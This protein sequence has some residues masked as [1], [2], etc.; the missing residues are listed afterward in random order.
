M[1]EFTDKLDRAAAAAVCGILQQGGAALI[2]AGFYGLGRSGGGGAGS[3][4][5][6]AAGLFASSFAG[7]PDPWNPQQ[8]PT[9]PVGPPIPLCYEGASEFRVRG[10]LNGQLNPPVTP[11]IKMIIGIRMEPAGFPGVNDGLEIAVMEW[12]QNGGGTGETSFFVGR[13]DSGNIYGWIQEF[14]GDPTCQVPSPPPGPQFPPYEYT[15]VDGCQLTVN[16][17][18]FAGTPQGVGPV[19][20]ISPSGDQL[21][22]SGPI[23]GCNFQPVLHYG[24]PAGGPP[25]VAPWNPDWDDAPPDDP[26]PWGPV[27]DEIA[28]GIGAAATQ[29]QIDEKFDTPLAEAQYV[30]NSIC[31]IDPQGNPIQKE[32]RVAIPDLAPW[33][34][35]IARLDALVPLLQG[36]KNFKQPI[37]N[38]VKPQGEFRTIG[39]ISDEVSPNG[40]SRLIKRLRYRSV[41]GIGLDALID[42]WKDFSFDA[43]PV[44]VKHR[45]ASWG[46]ITVWAASV[47]EGKRVI[48]H[49]AGE[50]LIDADQVGRWEISGSSSTRLGMPGTMRINTSGGYYWI[51]ARD[52]P[53]ERPIVGTT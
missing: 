51:T 29:E 45:G 2:T 10:L 39:F 38:D 31:E 19:F 52:G 9:V 18:G 5:L 24:D 27:L 17:Q 43:G 1:S 42:Y 26:F 41:S 34:A 44:T 35:I 23:G 33:E 53:T 36:Q 46:T 14:I 4:G 13:D 47:D 37:C 21:L 32:V 50:A 7:C 6:G 20:Q 16:F 8:P 30:L 11:L 40:K 12:K 3:I 49:A 15:D 48:R 28:E 25:D 22:R